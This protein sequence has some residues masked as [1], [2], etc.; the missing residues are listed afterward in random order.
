MKNNFGK[1]DVKIK[2]ALVRQVNE[3]QTILSI[4]LHYLHKCHQHYEDLDPAL[5]IS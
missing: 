1:T 3:R 4:A 5:Y 2:A